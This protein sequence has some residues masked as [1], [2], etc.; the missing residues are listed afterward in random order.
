MITVVSD[1]RHQAHAVA[2]AFAGWDNGSK[3][4]RW[5]ADRR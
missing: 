2:D 4:L 3:L 5:A 1:V